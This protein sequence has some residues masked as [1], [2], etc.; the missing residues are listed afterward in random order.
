LVPFYMVFA[1]AFLFKMVNTI[2]KQNTVPIG[3]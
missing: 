1:Q 3:E 2:N